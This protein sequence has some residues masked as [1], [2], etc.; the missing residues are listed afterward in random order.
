MERNS[1]VILYCFY[2]NICLYL[3]EFWFVRASYFIYS[4]S[5]LRF[6]FYSAFSG[7]TS[8]YLLIYQLRSNKILKNL[9]VFER[10]TIA[11]FNVLFTMGRYI[12]N[13]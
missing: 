10:W 7:Q 13:C 6:A 3:I 11:L 5:F 2:K 8:K 4:F 1:K 12:K 9:L